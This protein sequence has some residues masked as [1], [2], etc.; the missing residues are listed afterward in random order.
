MDAEGH[1]LDY[2]GA[3]HC[4]LLA[5]SSDSSDSFSTSAVFT[6]PSCGMVVDVRHRICMS[7]SSPLSFYEL[8]D[9]HEQDPATPSVSSDDT[10]VD[11]SQSGISALDVDADAVGQAEL[12][13]DSSG[14]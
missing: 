7:C 2:S 8:Q 5:S 11:S 12:G 3:F 10:I 4:G 9:A 13:I 1:D 6:C 14:F